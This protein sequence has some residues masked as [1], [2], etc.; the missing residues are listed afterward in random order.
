MNGKIAITMHKN[1]IITAKEYRKSIY[2]DVYYPY[3]N[4][5]VK[6]TCVKM[7][8]SSNAKNRWA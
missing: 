4:P 8:F 3:C 5:I 2:K 6:M 1:K 7:D